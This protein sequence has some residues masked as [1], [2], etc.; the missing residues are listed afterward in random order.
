MA[1]PR[2][3]MH[4][5]DGSELQL[6]LKGGDQTLNKLPGCRP[7]VIGPTREFRPVGKWERAELTS[8]IVTRPP[9]PSGSKA[10]AIVLYGGRYNCQG[11]WLLKPT[12]VDTPEG[13]VDPPCEGIPEFM[14]Q[15]VYFILPLHWGPDSTMDK[16]EKCIGEFLEFLGKAKVDPGSVAPFSLCG[17]SSGGY[18]VYDKSNF[19][20]MPWKFIG[21]IDPVHPHKKSKSELLDGSIKRIRGVYCLEN[22]GDVKDSDSDAYW[23]KEFHDHLH[24]MGAQEER[25]RYV[26]NIHFQMPSIFFNSKY[27]DE[28]AT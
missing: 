27:G 25:I 6:D 4:P 9:L 13:P 12:T 24:E 21:L 8:C 3:S 7:G 11:S 26:Q 19:K 17:F 14:L 22:W 23:I 20:C 28:L 2:V 16:C 15:R 1:T 5:V 18:A 10:P